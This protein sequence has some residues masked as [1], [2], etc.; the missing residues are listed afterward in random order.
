MGLPSLQ[1]L[2]DSFQ[3][4]ALQMDWS[5]QRPCL[6]ERHCRLQAFKLTLK[7]HNHGRQDVRILTFLPSGSA[8][9]A[10]MR[11]YQSVERGSCLHSWLANSTPPL[12]QADPTPSACQEYPGSSLLAVQGHSAAQQPAV[13]VSFARITGRGL[14]QH[15]QR[16]SS[17]PCAMRSELECEHAAG[18][19]L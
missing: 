9:V 12:L 3:S 1:P 19:T 11:G 8:I 10:D 17:D 14:Q 15:N 5:F 16:P 6:Q 18:K 2:P 7:L 4:S 13:W